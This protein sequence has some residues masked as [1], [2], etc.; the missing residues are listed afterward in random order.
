[1]TWGARWRERKRER[2]YVCNCLKINF[3]LISLILVGGEELCANRW[4]CSSLEVYMFMF[5]LHLYALTCGMCR[6]RQVSLFSLHAR[7][8][9]RRRSRKEFEKCIFFHYF[10]WSGLA[11]VM[12]KVAVG[13]F[14]RF[15]FLLQ[16]SS[17]QLWFSSC[18]LPSVV[19]REQSLF[20]LGDFQAVLKTI[21]VKVVKVLFLVLLSSLCTSDKNLFVIFST[22]NWKKR[23]KTER[24]KSLETA[25]RKVTKTKKNSSFWFS[26]RY[27][28]SVGGAADVIGA[29]ESLRY[30]MHL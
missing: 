28:A 27:K 26:F 12:R 21:K 7:W 10:F 13:I 1:M 17:S 22:W 2:G 15:S 8:K 29:L 30:G 23:K 14:F 11:R 3:S 6:W 4:E 19:H 5:W 20:F 9:E 16:K 25:K 24:R 18:Q